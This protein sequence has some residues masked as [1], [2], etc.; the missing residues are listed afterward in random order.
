MGMAGTGRAAIADDE[1]NERARCPADQ[2]VKSAPPPGNLAA[3]ELGRKR[4]RIVPGLVSFAT[5][6]TPDKRF[7]R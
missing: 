2:I 3:K 5:G 6:F 1:E 7:Q 4:G